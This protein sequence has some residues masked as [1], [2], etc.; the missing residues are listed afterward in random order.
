M[1][2]LLFFVLLTTLV[3]LIHHSTYTHIM[4]NNYSKSFPKKLLQKEQNQLYNILTVKGCHQGDVKGYK[5][6]KYFT[7]IQNQ[8][9]LMSRMDNN[10]IINVKS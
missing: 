2:N 6:I 10:V 4:Q 7:N 8:Y 1:L 5:T 3:D 9:N